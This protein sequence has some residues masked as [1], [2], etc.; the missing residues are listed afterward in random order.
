M[1][2]P[3]SLLEL[4][5]IGKDTVDK[6]TNELNVVRA[7]RD[8]LMVQLAVKN[9]EFSWL[10][11]RVNALELERAQLVEKVHGIRPAVPEIASK[12]ITMPQTLQ[13][14]FEDMG[15]KAARE[16]GMVAYDE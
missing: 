3:S 1:W 16:T 10:S 8:L 13:A 6:L 9:N 15:D 11:Q 12:P 4:F 5:K 2:V 7:E 14:L